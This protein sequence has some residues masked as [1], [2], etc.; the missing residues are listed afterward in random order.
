MITP[1]V[2]ISQR[3]RLFVTPAFAFI[4]STLLSCSNPNP[5]DPG[6]QP[7]GTF[8]GKVTLFDAAGNSLI[9]DSGVTISNGSVYQTAITD[10]PGDWLMP[11]VQPG[12]NTLTFT[13]SGFGTV[14]Q[15]GDSASIKDTTKVPTVVLSQPPALTIA[16]LDYEIIAPKTLSFTC[17]MPKGENLSIVFCLSTDSASLAA[18][19]C[20]AEWTFLATGA[21][22]N[23]AGDFAVS[24]DSTLSVDSIAHGTIMYATVC[25]AGN[26][27][28]YLS[29]S[30]YFDPVAK[31]EVYTALGTHSRVI[32]VKIP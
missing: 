27:P 18:N 22:N 16:F 21:G 14:M 12:N 30:H 32:A 17:S 6:P 5:G 2:S 3:F 26:G 31:R 1:S 20:Q 9:S 25:V 4:L 28:N 23:Y 24:S 7:T 11:Y 13:K 10:D 15:F 8:S 29:F 19:P